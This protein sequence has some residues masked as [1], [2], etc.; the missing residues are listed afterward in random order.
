MP[1]HEY[2][3]T[4]THSLFI[5]ISVF[6][7]ISVY[8]YLYYY[9]YGSISIS[10]VSYFSLL[11]MLWC[12]LPVLIFFIFISCVYASAQNTIFNERMLSKSD[13]IEKFSST[14]WWLYA[15]NVFFVFLSYMKWTHYLYAIIENSSS[16]FPI[17]ANVDL[18]S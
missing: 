12:K 5:S 15:F 4:H 14:W 16:D 1:S 6:I 11:N 7:W 2:K 17:F 13:F 9:L 10:I 18:Q 3:N 8:L